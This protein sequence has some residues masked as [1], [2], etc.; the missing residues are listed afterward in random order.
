ML[1]A[2]RK[3]IHCTECDYY[4]SEKYLSIEQCPWCNKLMKE[5][6]DGIK[7]FFKL[8]A[9]GIVDV[10]D[11]PGSSIKMDAY[12]WRH[13]ANATNLIRRQL[14]HKLGNIEKGVQKSDTNSPASEQT[15]GLPEGTGF[16]Q[17]YDDKFGCMINYHMPEN[18]FG[19]INIINKEK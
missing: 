12:F 10:W 17:K 13:Q 15:G 2:N 16:F 11:I 14:H 5:V 19:N 1:P 6:K 3:G 18:Y 4:L 7:K 8:G 9:I